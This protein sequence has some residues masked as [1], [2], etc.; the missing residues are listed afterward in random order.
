MDGGRVKGAGERNKA[1]EE[2]DMLKEEFKGIFLLSVV[3]NA[4]QDT[5]REV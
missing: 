4:L 2:E 3:W 5:F 1:L